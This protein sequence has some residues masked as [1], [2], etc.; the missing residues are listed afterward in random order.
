MAPYA[1]FHDSITIG[2]GS[3]LVGASLYLM[4][5]KTGAQTWQLQWGSLLPTFF[6]VAQA[7]SFAR[8]QRLT[9]DF[10]DKSTSI[11]FQ[12]VE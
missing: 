2:L 8:R 11:R 4:Q 12:L 1:K 3:N 5:K 6:W 9:A 10:P 7:A